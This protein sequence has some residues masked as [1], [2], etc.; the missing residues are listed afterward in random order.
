M[1]R[2]SAGRWIV[3]GAVV[4]VAFG[5]LGRGR[6]PVADAR[7]DFTIDGRGRGLM[8][9]TRGDLVLTIENPFG[10]AI[11]V[12]RVRVNPDGAKFPLSFSGMAKRP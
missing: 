10:F 8:P 3:R 12:E 1:G 6:L 5:V 9:R 11:L 4:L 7:D 2:R